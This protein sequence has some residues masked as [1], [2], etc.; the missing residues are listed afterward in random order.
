MILL[1]DPIFAVKKMMYKEKVPSS[2]KFGVAKSAERIKRRLVLLFISTASF[3]KEP[4]KGKSHINESV[5]PR[6]RA[7]NYLLIRVV[8]NGQASSPDLCRLVITTGSPISRPS[9][10]L[11]PGPPLQLTIR[12][13][14]ALTRNR[15]WYPVSDF[16]SNIVPQNTIWLR[17]P[18][19]KCIGMP[20]MR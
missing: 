19:R 15:N 20:L 17:R 7:E 11:H 8:N 16:Q 14:C 18:K 1:P 4:A 5:S 3:M 12:D 6:Q 2:L 10:K 9:V 13:G